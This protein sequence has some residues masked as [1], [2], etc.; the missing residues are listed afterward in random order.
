MLPPWG[1]SLQM[2]TVVITREWRNEGRYDISLYWILSGPSG[3]IYSPLLPILPFPTTV[4]EGKQHCN[5]S[6]IRRKNSEDTRPVL[7]VETIFSF[8]NRS[9]LANN[10][11]G[12]LSIYIARC[13]STDNRS[14]SPSLK[15]HHQK[16]I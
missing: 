5:V 8:L 9:V 14:P 2:R 4:F 6:S 1:G 13:K 16:I 7:M 11:T 15:A 12:S 10:S 3:N